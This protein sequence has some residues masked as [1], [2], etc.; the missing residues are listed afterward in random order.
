LEQS[1]ELS[2][3]IAEYELKCQAR[4]GDGSISFSPLKRM[5]LPSTWKE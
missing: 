5:M 2:L 3:T 4:A 1:V